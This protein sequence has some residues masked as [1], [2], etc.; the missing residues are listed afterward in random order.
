MAHPLRMQIVERVGRRGTARA[1]DVAEDLGIAANSVSYHLRTLA[2]GGVVVE[3]PESARDKRDRVWKLAQTNFMHAPTRESLVDEEYLSASGATTL[4]ALDWIRAG[5]VAESAQRRAHFPEDE[6]ALPP[7]M[8]FSTPMR[9]SR[10]QAR[11]L[12]AAVTERL[13]EFNR[14]NRDAH[15]ADLPG[16][17]DSEGAAQ[18]FRVLFTVLGERPAA[19]ADRAADEAPADRVPKDQDP[20]DRDPTDREPTER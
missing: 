15:G 11:E 19:P 10:A 17:P 2:R 4:A 18:D 14:I 8:L 16:D 9:L 12:F 20:T 3:A 5:W 13:Q 1:A 6:S 7:A